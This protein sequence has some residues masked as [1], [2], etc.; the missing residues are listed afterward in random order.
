MS[1]TP[2][3][4]SK[5]LRCSGCEEIEQAEFKA[6]GSLSEKVRAAHRKYDLLHQEFVRLSEAVLLNHG[7]LPVDVRTEEGYAG[8]GWM[9]QGRHIHRVTY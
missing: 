5:P 9:I 8:G 3:D 2:F 7:K 6:L 1:Y 4:S